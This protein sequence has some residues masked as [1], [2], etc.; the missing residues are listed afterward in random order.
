MFEGPVAS[1]VRHSRENAASALLLSDGKESSCLTVRSSAESP[2]P[3]ALSQYGG[4]R[5]PLDQRDNRHSWELWLRYQAPTL[6]NGRRR[7]TRAPTSIASTWLDQ[8]FQGQQLLRVEA[9]LIRPTIAMLVVVETGSSSEHAREAFFSTICVFP[10]VA[11][12][13]SSS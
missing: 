7:S 4:R 5:S 2:S 10:R 8:V 6:V 3:L 1:R 12:V 13:S 9:Q 11:L